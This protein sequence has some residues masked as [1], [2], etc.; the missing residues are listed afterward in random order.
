MPITCASGAP[1]SSAPGDAT[2]AGEDAFCVLNTNSKSPDTVQGSYFIVGAVLCAVEKSISFNY[3]ATATEHDGLTFREDDPCF[4][5]GGFDAN[6]DTDID[7]VIPLSLQDIAMASGDYDYF[8]GIQLGA[9]TYNVVAEPDVRFYLKDSGGII[10]A[11]IYQEGNE[12]YVEFVMDSNTGK[13]YYENKDYGN[14][15]HIRLAATGTFSP[16]TGSFTSVADAQYIHTEGEETTTSHSSMMDFSGAGDSYDHHVDGVRDGDYSAL[17]GL[18]YDTDF[19]TW[20][21]RAIT[22]HDPDLDPILDLSTFDM[23]F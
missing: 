7:D 4:G 18:T 12:G 5:P 9:A 10:A 21:V 23:T 20:G 19:Y 17:V 15:R 2:F 11:R 8:V 13:F 3:G 14:E 1:T 22:D 6:D 16:A